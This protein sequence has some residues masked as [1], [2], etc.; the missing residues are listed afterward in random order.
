MASAVLDLDLTSPEVVADPY[1]HFAAARAAAPVQWHEGLG[2]WLTFTRAAADTV[3]RTRSLGRLWAPRWPDESMDYFDLIHVHSLL[4]NEPPTHTR[5]RRLV[6]GAF[7][8]GHVER[9]RPRIAELAERLADGLADAGADGSPVD[10][11]AGYAEPLPVQVIAELLG[12][13]EADWQLLRPWSNA[14][15]KMY[16]YAV[17]PDQRA[18]AETAAREFVEYLRA[19]VA[20]RRQAPGDDLVS[21][22]IAETDVEGGRLTEDELVTTCTLLLN[23]GHEASVNVVGNG[24]TALLDHPD[25]L[26]A[27][28]ADPALV[29]TAVEELIRYDSPLQLFERTAIEDTTVEDVTVPAGAKIAALLGAANRDPAAFDEPDR[30][31]VTRTP[32][33]HIGFGAGIHFCVGAPLARVELQASLGT[34]LRRFPS[35]SLA[36]RPERRPEFVIRGVQSLPVTL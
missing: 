11:I 1:P 14:I 2:M 4:E 6:A 25:Q 23:A 20:L 35:L 3:L 13:P 32:N 30:F 27:L 15:V 12:V 17:S 16:E 28:R 36:A 9:L 22:L 33:P 7:A 26:A 5:L 19:L 10:L 24:V 34:L 29:P 31:D 8:R 21:S 18:G